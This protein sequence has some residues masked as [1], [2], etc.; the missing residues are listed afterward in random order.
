VETFRVTTDHFA[1]CWMS[2]NEFPGVTMRVTS[3]GTM[4]VQSSMLL[5]R[6]SENRC[7]AVISNQ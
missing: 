4:N 5:D 7:S 6:R 3:V 1:C 2:P